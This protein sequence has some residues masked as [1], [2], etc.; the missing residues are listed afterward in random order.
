MELEAIES[1]CPS[2]GE[3]LTIPIVSADDDEAR[4]STEPVMAHI[5]ERHTEQD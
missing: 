3:A 1:R 5:R 2:C 4:F